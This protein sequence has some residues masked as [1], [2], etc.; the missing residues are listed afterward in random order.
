MKGTCPR[1]EEQ[2][3]SVQAE[4]THVIVGGRERKAIQFLCSS[5]QA[6]LSVQFDPRERDIDL[7][8]RLVRDL[9]SQLRR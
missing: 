6:I 3:K 5:C 9:R 2:P 7:S 8:E 1:C 4:T